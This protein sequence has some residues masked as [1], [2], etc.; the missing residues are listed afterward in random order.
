MKE[1]N[2]FQIYSC[3]SGFILSIDG[4][5]ISIATQDKGQILGFVS[6]F[7]ERPSDAIDS[8][9]ELY[10]PEKLAMRQKRR[11]AEKGLWGAVGADVGVGVGPIGGA[12]QREARSYAE[13]ESPRSAA[14]PCPGSGG[15]A[16]DTDAR[17]IRNARR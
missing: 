1:T 6:H 2:Q 12:Y 15:R 17:S 16:I 11:S 14:N 8:M 9:L 7:L 5:D 10:R 13:E 3:D 4:D